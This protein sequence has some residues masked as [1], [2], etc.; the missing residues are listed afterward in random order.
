[1]LKYQK[2]KIFLQKSL[3]QIGLKKF[4]GLI[5]LK[6]PFQ[7]HILLVML[8]AKKLLQHSTKKE[9]QNT[10]LKEFIIEIVIKRKGDKLYFKQKGYDNSFNSSIDKKG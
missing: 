2:I 8:K 10:K 5:W 4:Q 6:I 1:M 9:L 7:E 3:F